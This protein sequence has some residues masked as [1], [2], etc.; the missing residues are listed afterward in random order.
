MFHPEFPI[1]LK[2]RIWVVGILSREVSIRDVR[3]VA[4]AID[5]NFVAEAASRYT[6]ECGKSLPGVLYAAEGVGAPGDF[7]KIILDFLKSEEGREFIKFIFSL[8]GFII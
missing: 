5:E 4:S 6:A 1:R 3:T 8:F 7:L 2:A